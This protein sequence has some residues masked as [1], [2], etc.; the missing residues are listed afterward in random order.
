MTLDETIRELVRQE[1][2]RAMRERAP[3][4]PPADWLSTDEA[5]ELAGVQ[6]KTVRTWVAAGMPAT[7]RGRRL[8]IARKVLESYRSGAT[9]SASGL[10]SSLTAPGK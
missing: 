3:E 10:L 8:V 2:E 6:P 7:R 4:R 1:V 9:P 5:A